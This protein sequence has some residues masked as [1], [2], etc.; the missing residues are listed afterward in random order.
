MKKLQYEI[1]LE[2][3]FPQIVRFHVSP[4]LTR[5]KQ[6]TLSFLGTLLFELILD[7]TWHNGR[8]SA[9]IALWD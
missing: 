4:L 2:L 7:V 6:I 3:N 9:V 8:Q 1:I 5:Q